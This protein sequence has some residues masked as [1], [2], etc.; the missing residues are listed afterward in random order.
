MMTKYQAVYRALRATESRSRLPVG[1]R[2]PTEFGFACCAQ[3]MSARSQRGERVE[4]PV[5][6]WQRDLVTQDSSPPRWHPGQTMQS[7][8]RAR[9]RSCPTP[10]PKRPVDVPVSFRG[11]PI[12]VVRARERFQARDAGRPDVGGVPYPPPPGCSPTPTSGCPNRVFSRDA[13]R[14]SQAST[15][16]LLTPRTQPRIFAMLT[17]GDLVRRQKYPSG[18]EARSPDS[19]H[20]VP[21]LAG[22]IK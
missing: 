17:T 12:E 20:D 6:G 2:D 8:E 4:E 7:G 11:I 10:R 14:M 21:R 13:K 22:Q 19:S 1:A 18:L 9:R 5:G 15:N 16:S 3:A